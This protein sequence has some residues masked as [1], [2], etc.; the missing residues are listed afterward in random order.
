MVLF[1]QVRPLDEGKLA[2]L[3]AQGYSRPLASLLLLRGIEDQ[4]QAEA[5]LHPSLD[6]LVS[7]FLFPDM[8]AAVD[9][10]NAAKEKGEKVVIYGDYDADGVT[11][12]AL[13]YETFLEY[14]ILADFYIPDRHEEGYGLNK[15]AVERLAQDHSL[16]VTVDCGISSPDEVALAKE[17]HMDVI[18]TD[19][20]HLPERLP[21]CPIIDPKGPG[22]PFPHLAG[23]GVAF[24]L[25]EALC[26]REAAEK[27]LDLAALG[28]VADIVD[29]LGEN[30][31]IVSEG[32]R[33]INRG[34][35]PGIAALMEVCSLSGKELSSSHIGF[36][37]GPRINAGGR[38]GHS[39]RSVEMLVTEDKR[40]ALEIAASLDEHNQIRQAQEAS[41]MEGALR[42]IAQDEDFSNERA[43]VVAGEDWNPG[44][45]GIVA[46]RL[47]ERYYRPAFVL[48]KVNDTYVCSARSI[49]GVPLFSMLETMQ[50]LFLRFGGHDLAAGLTIRAG[51]LGAFKRRLE[52]TLAQHD[53]D[54]WIPRMRY[55]LKADL[56]ELTVDFLKEMECLQ[57]FGQGNQTPV[58]YLQDAKVLGAAAMGQNGSHLRLSLRQNEVT[59]DAA[60]FKMGSR[61]SE[62]VG[63]IQA[64]VVPEINVWQG[65][66]SV[67]L[68][69][70]Q[71]AP[72]V[73][74]FLES[75]AA[76]EESRLA[77]AL[78][79]LL[80]PVKP[81]F[82]RH[83]DADEG[84]VLALIEG[85]LN[86][87]LLLYSCEATA[88]RWTALLEEKGLLPRV[89]FAMGALKREN[90]ARNTLCA[91]GQAERDA[92]AGF[93]NLVLLDRPPDRA[94]VDALLELAPGALVFVLKEPGGLPALLKKHAPDVADTRTLY[95][96]LRAVEPKLPRLRSLEEL[97]RLLRDVLPCSL[98]GLWLALR[99]LEDMELC[100]LE[101]EPFRLQML[102]PTGGKRDFE[103]AQIVQRIRDFA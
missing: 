85:S 12:T 76:E 58:Y 45:V 41:I 102:S 78:P 36:M 84:K 49:R 38:I 24:K 8:R 65:R 51:D 30:R 23:V 75:A 52:D 94:A 19:H 21:D 64:A 66:V 90:P 26:G 46:S 44:V 56:S 1:E 62:A 55:D 61:I 39:A 91:L 2:A 79:L 92:Y 43:C 57:P 25:A 71:F 97:R 63:E 98:P 31:A 50:E 99:A 16:M 80:G 17:K 18:V 87:T 32:L 4:S 67:R 7:P 72:S 42:Q 89:S 15:K 77:A 29:L 48:A 53:E 9:R 93:R 83:L 68:L 88:R 11:S 28:T 103:K 10:L 33:R 101:S 96:A 82:K 14:G 59:M 86:G 34:P 6:Q 54:L 100:R 35:R 37:L 22:Y 3:Q 81:G 70:R 40:L 95:K 27:R 5:F 69:V 20:H 74:G 73:R 60:A 47:V 13:L